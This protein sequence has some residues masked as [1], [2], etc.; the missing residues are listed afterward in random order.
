MVRARLKDLMFGAAALLGVATVV[1]L[2]GSWIFG[3]SLIVL[4]TGSMAPSMPAGS[5]AVA[6]PI[7]AN[8]IAVGDVLTLPQEGRALPVTHRVVAVEELPGSPDTRVIE[9]RGDDNPVNDPEPYVVK[10]AQ[11]T[12]FTV[13]YLGR[14][15]TVLSAPVVMGAVTIVV[16]GFVVWALWPRPGR[17]GSAAS[18]HTG[19]R[20]SQELTPSNGP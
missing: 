2:L 9:M 7:A 19:V 8:E 15:A 5:A 17:S 4:T 10:Q 3:W 6:V 1:W 18:Q 13:P 14:V 11:R 12:V 20:A 16:A